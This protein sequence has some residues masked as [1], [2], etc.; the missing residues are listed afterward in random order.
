MDKIE[1]IAKFL[2][3]EVRRDEAEAKRVPTLSR[4]PKDVK[5]WIGWKGPAK[6][7]LKLISKKTDLISM[8]R[9]VKLA[10]KYQDSVPNDLKM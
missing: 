9:L 8:V 10:A 3:D 4:L 2:E 7:L 1:I 5:T 6:K